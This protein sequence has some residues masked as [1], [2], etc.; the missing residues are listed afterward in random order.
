[1]NF[2]RTPTAPEPA[3]STVNAALRDPVSGPELAGT[4][5]GGHPTLSGRDAL[6]AFTFFVEVPLQNQISFLAAHRITVSEA[7]QFADLHVRPQLSLG[8]LALDHAE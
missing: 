3:L 8:R 4:I 2:R 6:A 5:R 7:L 1:M